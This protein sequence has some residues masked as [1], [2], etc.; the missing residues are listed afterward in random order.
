MQNIRQN[1]VQLQTVR[2]YMIFLL[3]YEHWYRIIID[4]NMKNSQLH[5]YNLY[6]VI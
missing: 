2:I 6:F 3:S 4:L 5:V 1:V